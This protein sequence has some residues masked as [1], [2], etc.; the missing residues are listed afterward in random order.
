MMRICNLHSNNGRNRTLCQRQAVKLITGCP[1][2]FFRI[3]LTLLN[4]QASLLFCLR[5][6]QKNALRIRKSN[7]LN[8]L[9]RHWIKCKFQLK[10]V[11]CLFLLKDRG[12]G[13]SYSILFSSVRPKQSSKMKR[14]LEQAKSWSEQN[15]IFNDSSGSRGS[16]SEQFANRE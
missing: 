2:K 4:V 10:T 1:H 11:L 9:A 12:F 15:K 13:T 7:F 8:H 6:Y 5:S 16:I 3:L 14:L